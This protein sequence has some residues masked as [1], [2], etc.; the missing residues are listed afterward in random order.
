MGGSRYHIPTT[1]YLQLLSHCL[2][3]CNLLFHPRSA[4][5]TYTPAMPSVNSM[6]ATLAE[7]SVAK[8]PENRADSATRETSPARPG[9]IWDRTPIWVPREPMLPKP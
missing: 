5:H 6:P 9:A 3:A 8:T 7:V 1:Y 2:H 4:R